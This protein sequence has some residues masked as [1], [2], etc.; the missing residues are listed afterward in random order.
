M[1]YTVL[2][3]AIA[4]GIF[5]ATLI[6]GKATVNFNHKPNVRYLN[7]DKTFRVSEDPDGVKTV[8]INS[9][10]GDKDSYL[11]LIQWLNENQN[12]DKIRI[13]LSGNG[14][15]VTSLMDLINT[16]SNT[17][18]KE[19]IVVYGDVYSAH[20]VLTM[21]GDSVK[22]DNPNTLLLFHAPASMSGG[23]YIMMDRVCEDV[24]G[25]DRGIPAKDKCE[26]MME[27]LNRSW[28]AIA[29]EKVF[30]VLTVQE[31]IDYVNGYDVIVKAGEIERRMKK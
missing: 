1:K 25:K 15:S 3:A 13:Y 14:G 29:M 5:S 23:E 9:V 24:T 18:A 27:N 26:N 4:A 16:M 30:A 7:E 8:Y 12:D 6:S 17:K 21:N 22:F 20:A 10:I 28:N 2:A 11:P 19:E 31:R